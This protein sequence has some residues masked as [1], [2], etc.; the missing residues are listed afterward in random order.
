MFQLQ[1]V[2]ILFILF[3]ICLVNCF[4]R[5][6]FKYWD[7]CLFSYGAEASFSCLTLATA[8]CKSA[9]QNSFP[10]EI[11]DEAV[12]NETLNFVSSKYPR[13]PV[14]LNA[15]LLSPGNYYWREKNQLLDCIIFSIH[16][17]AFTIYSLNIWIYLKKIKKHDL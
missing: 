13:M 15:I 9:H 5:S 10:L 11:V 8:Y 2:I 14:V 3:S 1:C 17:L 7:H 16:Y 6:C 12:F 4:E